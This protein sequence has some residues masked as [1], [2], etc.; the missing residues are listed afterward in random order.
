M[1]V[2]YETSA[3]KD[4]VPSK[5]LECLKW[6]I[7][8]YRLSYTKMEVFVF[9]EWDTMSGWEQKGDYE[10]LDGVGICMLH[11]LPINKQ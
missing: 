5:W 10:L 3:G 4:I 9:S 2:V 6:A 11:V 7:G 8:G 1:P